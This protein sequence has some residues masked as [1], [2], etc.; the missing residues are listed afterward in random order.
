MKKA[1]LVG[2]E[3]GGGEGGETRNSDLHDHTHTHTHTHTYTYTHTHFASTQINAHA[4]RNVDQYARV[5]T[6]TK[7]HGRAH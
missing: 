6:H 2:T 4:C 5:H 7:T 3:V 1:L